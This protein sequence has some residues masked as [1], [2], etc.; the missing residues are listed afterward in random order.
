M[1]DRQTEIDV[2]AQGGEMKDVV[3]GHLKLEA[4]EFAYPSRPATQ[5]LKGLTI[6]AKPGMTVALVGK[7]GCGKSTVMG[8]AQRWY[9]VKGGSVQLDGI[10]TVKWDL[11][12]M[13]S[14][15]AIVGQ[16]PVLFNISIRDNI[17]Y[18]ALDGKCDDLAIYE[19]A[20]LANIHDFVMSLPEKYDTLVGEKVIMNSID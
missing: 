6:E 20:K 13:R 15:L 2:N 9:D 18:G 12:K 4:A 17:A 19:A 16:E 7:S 5:I 3:Q 10:E 1:L 8:L 11:K 14:F